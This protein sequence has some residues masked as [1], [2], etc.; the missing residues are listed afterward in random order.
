M[1]DG[2]REDARHLDTEKDAEI[3]AQMVPPKFRKIAKKIYKEQINE[4]MKPI[5][6]LKKRPVGS[7]DKEI[8]A[9]AICLK[10]HYNCNLFLASTDQ[11]FSPTLLVGGKRLTKI[12]EEIKNKFDIVCDWPNEILKAIS[13]I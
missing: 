4:R 3:Q 6:K 2:L 11:H 1:Y 12:T 13:K 5:R 8:L 9:E 7:R 10:K